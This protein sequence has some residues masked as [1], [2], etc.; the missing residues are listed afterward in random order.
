MA[1]GRWQKDRL[2]EDSDPP[3]NV[4]HQIKDFDGGLKPN[5]FEGKKINQPSALCPKTS[6]FEG[7][8]PDNAA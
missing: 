7:R 8:S 6:A 5:K 2:V 3:L 1:E 4:D